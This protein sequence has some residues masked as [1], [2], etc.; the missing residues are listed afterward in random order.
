LL[1]Y[2][3]FK[4]SSTGLPSLIVQGERKQK[5]SFRLAAESPGRTAVTGWQPALPRGKFTCA[6]RAKSEPDWRYTRDACATRR[7]TPRSG[8]MQACSRPGCRYRFGSSEQ[9]P[10]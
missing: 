9:D 4:V 5:S 10:N 8:N 1:R 3:L 2:L 7:K 6:G